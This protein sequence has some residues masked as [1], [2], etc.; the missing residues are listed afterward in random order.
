MALEIHDLRVAYG[1]VV[2]VQDLSLSVETGSVTSVIGPN[3]AG[4]TS[5]VRAVM[6]AIASSGRIELDGAPL[7]RGTTHKRVRAGIA[8]VP[9]GRGVFPDLTVKEH[10]QLAAGR[11]WEKRWD[12]LVALFPIIGEKQNSKGRELSG[13]QQQS[14][15]IARALA[16]RPRYIVLDEPSIGLSPVAIEGVVKAIAAMAES[17]EVGV[18]LAEQNSA[19]ALGLS[20]QVNVMVRGRI[21]R[22]ATP[23]E[24][25]GT[26]ELRNL[27][28]G[29]APD[30]ARP[31]MS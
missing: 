22:T 31:D 14:L 8:Y 1:P 4:K 25:R 11:G 28:L 13:G 26:D 3:G 12:E 9:D 27:Y 7:R 5:T 6:G 18:L 15:S 19:I 21:Q 2:A 17:G 29:L 10:I 16:P 23:D 20:T 24:L 30:A